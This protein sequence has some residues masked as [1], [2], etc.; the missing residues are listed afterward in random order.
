MRYG[1]E[2]AENHNLPSSHIFIMGIYLRCDWKLANMA[3]REYS[4]GGP[5]LSTEVASS[6]V[7]KRIQMYPDVCHEQPELRL[8]LFQWESS[9]LPH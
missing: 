3:R 7:A 2:Q 8:P 1:Q 4:A 5:H 6:S 9:S